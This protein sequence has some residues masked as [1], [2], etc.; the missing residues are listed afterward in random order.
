MSC[1]RQ[2][3]RQQEQ[4]EDDEVSQVSFDKL[5]ARLD[6]NHVP[7][8]AILQALAECTKRNRTEEA[9]FKKE[10]TPLSTISSNRPYPT[11]GSRAFSESI[12]HSSRG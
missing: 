9:C 3:Q 11:L 6:M 5:S 4:N 1:H 10:H 7:H 8:F 12:C 2:Q